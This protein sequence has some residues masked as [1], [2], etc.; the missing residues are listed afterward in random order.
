MTWMLFA[1]GQAPEMQAR[2]QA[3][4]CAVSADRPIMDELNVLPY[5]V[6]VVRETL[7]L[8]PPAPSAERIAVQVDIVPFVHPITDAIG[9]QHDKLG[10]RACIGYRFSIIGAKKILFTLLII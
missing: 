3:E 4:V 2:L 5:L 8:Y 6:H 7:R 1:L 10:S 9:V